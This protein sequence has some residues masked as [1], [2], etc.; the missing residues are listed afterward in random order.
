MGLDQIPQLLSVIFIFHLFDRDHRF[1][2]IPVK[3]VLCIQYIS[4][5]AAHTCRKVFAGL[6]KNHNPA[7]G[8]VFAAVLAYTFYHSAG[9]GISHCKPFSGHAVDKGGSAC[10][11]VKS[12][13]SHNNIFFCLISGLF[14]NFYD[15]P[16]AGQP[17]A[18]I[19]AVTGKTKRQTFWDKRS[20]T[21]SAGTFAVDYNGII[22]KTCWVLSG[23]FCSQDCS[24]CT[25]CIGHFHV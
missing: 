9:P 23:N 12:H 20:K 24:K 25:I 22:R 10:G 5:A 17:L 6:S 8:H 18:K 7:S 14:R 3:H 16:A 21:L 4:D 1:I 2:D 15:Q 11:A 13:I 19:I